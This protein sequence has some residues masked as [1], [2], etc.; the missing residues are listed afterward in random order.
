MATGPPPLALLCSECHCSHH[1][2][3]DACILL[4]FT[5]S[6]RMSAPWAGVI[7]G[8]ALMVPK[9]LGTEQAPGV[10]GVSGGWWQ[11]AEPEL[12][13]PVQLTSTGLGDGAAGPTRHGGAPCQPPPHPNLGRGQATLASSQGWFQAA[14]P[15]KGSEQGGGWLGLEST[16]DQPHQLARWR[17]GRE[18][19]PRSWRSQA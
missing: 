9:V 14:H 6:T 19:R 18:D 10:S 12:D 5:L 7:S 15:P 4:T 16:V 8:S 2:G 3:V 1:H 17:T 13:T 11:E